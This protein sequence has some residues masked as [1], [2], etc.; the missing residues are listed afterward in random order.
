MKILSYHSTLFSGIVD[1]TALL[2]LFEKVIALYLL[3]ST[4]IA[5]DSIFSH[6]IFF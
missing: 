4:S 5:I 2:L 3:N 6:L 1:V